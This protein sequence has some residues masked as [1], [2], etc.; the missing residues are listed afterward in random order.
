MRVTPKESDIEETI[1]EFLSYI[2]NS[3][4]TKIAPSGFFDGGVM[5]SHRSKHVQRGLSDIFFWTSGK[6]YAFEV[7]TEK[8]HAFANKHMVQIMTLPKGQLSKKKQHLKEQ[9]NFMLKIR[10][11]GHVAEFVSSVEDVQSILKST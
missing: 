11:A 6:F 5:K 3:F 10:E 1:L 4:A 8:E 7:K 2:P 9:L